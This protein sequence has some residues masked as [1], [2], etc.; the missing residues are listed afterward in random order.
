MPF[1]D[2]ILLSVK[3]AVIVLSSPCL[4]RRRIRVTSAG[5]LSLLVAPLAHRRLPRWRGFRHP[6][7]DRLVLRLEQRSALGDETSRQNQRPHG[8]F[9]AVS[10][11]HRLGD[12]AE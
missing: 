2:V 6:V 4:A 7:A 11:D 5:V 10:G 3:L 8:E 12:Q 9:L 1:C